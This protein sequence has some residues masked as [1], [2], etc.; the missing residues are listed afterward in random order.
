MEGLQAASKDM[1]VAI[2]HALLVTLDE[3]PKS[4]R[5][6]PSLL[7]GTFTTTKSGT[8]G[9]EIWRVAL[10]EKKKK[11]CQMFGFL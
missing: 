7:S 6:V 2:D 8:A 5:S 3:S 11:Y 10:S 1:A 9:D 4:Q